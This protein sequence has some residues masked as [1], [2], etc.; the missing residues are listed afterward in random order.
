MESLQS[1]WAIWLAL[2]LLL[3]VAIMIAPE[4]MRRTS[5][6]KLSRVFAGVKEARK[7]LRKSTRSVQKVEKKYQKLLARSERVKPRKLQEAKEAVED[8][9]GTGENFE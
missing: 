2:A 5:R 3:M 1:N 9:A 8:G 7:E 4:L 6:S